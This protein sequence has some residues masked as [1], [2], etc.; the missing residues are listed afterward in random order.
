MDKTY[1]WDV[2]NQNDGSIVL[3]DR[4]LNYDVR[5]D[6]E[7]QIVT[8]RIHQ[9]HVEQIHPCVSMCKNGKCEKALCKLTEKE[10]KSAADSF[11]P[12][13]FL[14]DPIVGKLVHITHMG[15]I[16]FRDLDGGVNE[17]DMNWRRLRNLARPIVDEQL[18]KLAIS[19]DWKNSRVSLHLGTLMLD[20]TIVRIDADSYKDMEKDDTNDANKD[21]NDMLACGQSWHKK[22]VCEKMKREVREEEHGD[23]P[24]RRKTA[25]AT[26]LEGAK[27]TDM[28]GKDDNKPEAIDTIENQGEK[29]KKEEDKGQVVREDVKDGGG[30][31]DTMCQHCAENPCVWAVRREDMRIFDESEHE[32]LPAE[33]RPPNN[34][35]R[36]KVY[37]QMFLYIN[38]GPSGK[39]V[40]MELPECVEDGARLM[41]PS[42]AYMGFRGV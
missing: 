20:N 8:K 32:H 17:L 28:K 19:G 5:Y 1:D 10:F 6:V 36:K 34:I 27:H 37:R 30:E 38:Q 26:Y 41:F 23:Y 39:G 25:F 21:M 16:S 33:D 9:F 15:K 14:K 4:H 22:I 11:D 42:P 18:S 2:F 3:M 7:D 31:E 29:R 35:R 12:W 40:R 24:K 13:D